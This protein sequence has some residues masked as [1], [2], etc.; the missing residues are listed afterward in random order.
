MHWL[1][2]NLCGMAGPWKAFVPN[3]F[4]DLKGLCL[5]SCLLSGHRALS[6]DGSARTTLGQPLSSSFLLE[7]VHASVLEPR[8]L[9]QKFEFSLQLCFKRSSCSSHQSLTQTCQKHIPSR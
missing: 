3:D 2:T 1:T 4:L 5:T 9:W 7:L 6:Q 8:W